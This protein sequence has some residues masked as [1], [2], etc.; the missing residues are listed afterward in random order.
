MVEVK[1]VNTTREDQHVK[2]A[3]EVKFVVTTSKDRVV[4]IVVGVQYVSTTSK[5]QDV[6]F[7]GRGH[8]CE[9]NKIK[10]SCPTSDPLGHLASI[11]RGRVYTA[12]KNN[13]EI[14]STEY[15]GCNIEIF[16]KQIEQQFTEDM[17]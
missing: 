17:S 5:D 11:V 3:A 13:K 7:C 16:K 10:L 6:F 8:I 12:L 9:H 14:S 1:F 4:R 2:T 15:L